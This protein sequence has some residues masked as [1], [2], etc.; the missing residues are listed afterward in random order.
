MTQRQTKEF[1]TLRPLPLRSMPL[2]PRLYTSTV[3]GKYTYAPRQDTSVPSEKTFRPLVKDKWGAEVSFQKGAGGAEVVGAEVS[4]P[5][6]KASCKFQ[7]LSI[8]WDCHTCTRHL[9]AVRFLFRLKAYMLHDITLVFDKIIFIFWIK[10]STY[11]RQMWETQVLSVIKTSAI[12]EK[13]C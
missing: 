4:N 2:R 3:F 12:S 1:W 7:R 5:Q 10:W 11:R 9:R 8:F 13:K 6:T